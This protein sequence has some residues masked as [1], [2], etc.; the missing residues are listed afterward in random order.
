MRNGIKLVKR[1]AREDSGASLIEY[2]LLAA[3]IA[4]GCIVAFSAAGEGLVALFGT[5]AG[6]QIDGAADKI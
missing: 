3:L 1:F 5:G 6:D 4:V 2:G